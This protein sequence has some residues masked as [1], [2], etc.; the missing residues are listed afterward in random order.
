MVFHAQKMLYPKQTFAFTVLFLA[1]GSGQSFLC[2]VYNFILYGY[3]TKL[4]DMQSNWSNSAL[5]L[6]KCHD[7]FAS[8]FAATERHGNTMSLVALTMVTSIR[9]ELWAFRRPYTDK[10]LPSHN[11]KEHVSLQ[12]ASNSIII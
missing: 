7:S 11:K 2:I 9:E 3:W 12:F 10:K 1:K 4:D 6:T 5:L 8:G